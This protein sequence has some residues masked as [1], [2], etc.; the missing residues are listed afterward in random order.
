MGL[1]SA[2]VGAG[3]SGRAGA[4]KD[5]TKRQDEKAINKA[6]VRQK[7]RGREKAARQQDSEA[8]RHP[9]INKIM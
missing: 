1:P 2:R 9:G 7:G 8:P 5:R 4:G 3:V 6:V